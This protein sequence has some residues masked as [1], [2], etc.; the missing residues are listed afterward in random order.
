MKKICLIIGLSLLLAIFVSSAIAQK[1][2]LRYGHANALTY[3]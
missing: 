3:P 1:V 2:T